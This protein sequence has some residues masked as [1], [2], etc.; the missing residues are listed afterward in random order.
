[1]VRVLSGDEVRDPRLVELLVATVDAGASVNYLAPMDPRDAEQAWGAWAGEVERGT[2]VVLADEARTG[3]V[4]LALASQPNGRHRAEVQKM[5]VHPSA[6]RQGLG[7][8]LLTAAEEHAV[9]LGV[10]LLVLDTEKGGAGEALYETCGWQRVGEIP[11]FA[12]SSD[13]SELVAAVL[14]YKQL[15]R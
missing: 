11:G 13:G 1:M 14:F 3:C 4:H 2:R 8:A 5:L 6:R 9:K 15:T 10:S 7:R 12:R